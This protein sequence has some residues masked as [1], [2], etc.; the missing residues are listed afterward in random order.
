MI[1]LILEKVPATLRGELSRWLLEP[2]HGVF[3]GNPSA[4]VRD[5]LW[6]M[7]TY[8]VKT[9]GALLLYTYPNE[10]GFKARAVGDTTRS[11]RDCE[12]LL[13]VHIPTE[14]AKKR[15]PASVRASR[16]R[17]T[18]RLSSERVG[19][20]EELVAIPSSEVARGVE[21]PTRQR[22]SIPRVR[23][24]GKTHPLFGHQGDGD[25]VDIALY[26]HDPGS[27]DDV[28]SWND[29][30]TD[31]VFVVRWRSPVVR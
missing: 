7:V 8:R 31:S 18:V 19:N 26:R 2:R 21:R 13:M 9:G 22:S 17:A 28:V 6:E 11:L 20:G 27:Q 14:Q 10:Q 15:D 24:L 4:M 1:V 30:V 3:V 29:T 25:A 5:R 12:G 23:P 16:Q